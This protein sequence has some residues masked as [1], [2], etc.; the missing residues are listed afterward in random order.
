MLIGL[1]MIAPYL[2]FRRYLPLKQPIHAVFASGVFPF[3]LQ[4]LL[5]VRER[6]YLPHVPWLSFLVLMLLGLFLVVG[7]GGDPRDLGSG[8]AEIGQSLSLR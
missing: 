5:S 2:L 4:M 3:P 6:S 7:G 1:G 8:G